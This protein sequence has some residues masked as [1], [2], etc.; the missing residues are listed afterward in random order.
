[1]AE[2]IQ[3]HKHIGALSYGLEVASE[4]M[5]KNTHVAYCKGLVDAIA[6][7]DSN[8]PN[9]PIADKLV[10]HISKIMADTSTQKRVVGELVKCAIELQ[11][12]VSN[13]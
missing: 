3:A 4:L 7:G 13:G 11:K 5:P 6:L 10:I 2:I 12:A 8:H 1:M 9:K